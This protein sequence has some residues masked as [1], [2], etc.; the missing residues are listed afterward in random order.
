MLTVRYV[1]PCCD[2]PYVHL[3][4][5]NGCSRVGVIYTHAWAFSVV[6]LDDLGNARASSCGMGKRRIPR[7]VFVEAMA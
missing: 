3:S 5:M 4:C 2:L 7:F 1:V 6:R